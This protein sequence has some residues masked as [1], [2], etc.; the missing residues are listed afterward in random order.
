MVLLEEVH[1]IEQVGVEVVGE[2][3]FD[4]QA[5]LCSQPALQV[6]LEL[7]RVYPAGNGEYFTDDS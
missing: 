1:V 3:L 5:E 2:H 4:G 6:F 7:A